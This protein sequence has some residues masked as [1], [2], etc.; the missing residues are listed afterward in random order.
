MS[1]ND[2]PGSSTIQSYVDSAVGAAQN[3]LSSITGNPADQAE[4]KALKSK[5]EQ[6]NQNSHT[7][8]RLGPFTADPNTGAAVSD[9][10]DRTSGSW[11]QTV[12][13][14]KESFGNLIGN[15]NLRQTGIQQNADGKAQQAKGQLLDLGQGMTD[16]ARGAVGAL[17]SAVLGDKEGQEKWQDL[18]DEGKTRQR[19]VEADLQKGEQ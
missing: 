4:A 5:A 13:A 16:R 18:H 17:G 8:A 6:E 19:G 9:N 1:S 2:A 14:A 12:G 15:E 10:Q 3:V 7:T 11:N